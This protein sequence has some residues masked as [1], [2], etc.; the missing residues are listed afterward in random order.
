H[1]GKG[2]GWRRSPAEDLERWLVRALRHGDFERGGY[3]SIERLKQTFECSE[4]LRRA[5]TRLDQNARKTRIDYS[6][7]GLQPGGGPGGRLANHFVVG[8]MPTQWSEARNF[9]PWRLRRLPWTRPRLQ[10]AARMWALGAGGAD[11]DT[12]ESSS[13][14]DLPDTTAPAA[15][16]KAEA[17]EGA[18]AAASKERAA[19]DVDM[20]DEM[21]E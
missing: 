21:T 19:A 5:A 3:L 12:E 8:P 13:D 9:R 11:A 2:K 7:P 14:S 20:G 10:P 17:P 1:H 15:A 6:R 16:P 18:A 4:E